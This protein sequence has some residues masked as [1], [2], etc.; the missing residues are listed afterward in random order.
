MRFMGGGG[1]ESSGSPCWHDVVGAIW[2]EGEGGG[3][4]GMD[5]VDMR[6][7]NRDSR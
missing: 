5:G 7:R 6:V 4:Y 1:R 2:G 3:G